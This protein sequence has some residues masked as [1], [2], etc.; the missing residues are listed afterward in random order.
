MLLKTHLAITLAFILL[1]INSVESK[2]VF[3]IVALIATYIP[4]VDSRYS[5]L[6][7]KKINRILQLFTKHR[8]MIHSF[9]F[10]LTITLFLILFFPVLAF[11][12]FL[13]YGLH[14]FADSFTKDGI[15]PFYPWKKRAYG[16]VKTGGRIEVIILVGFVIADIAL[17]FLRIF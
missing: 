12:F 15:R 13:G 10:L 9:S 6:G 5:T 14:L 4:D 11:G 17:V 2:L 8:G 3:V 16:F 7:R 1:F